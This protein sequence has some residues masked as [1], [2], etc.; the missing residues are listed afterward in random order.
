MLVSRALFML[1]PSLKRYLID[2]I[3]WGLF[4]KQID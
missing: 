3:A 2:D 4:M 1:K